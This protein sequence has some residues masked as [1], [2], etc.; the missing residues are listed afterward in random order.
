MHKTRN[1]RRGEK[2][3]QKNCKIFGKE[4]EKKETERTQ[5]TKHITIN[6]EFLRF[7]SGNR[8][9]THTNKRRKKNGEEKR[10]E[11]KSI[12]YEVEQNNK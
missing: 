12:G 2:L 11:W 9:H 7:A 8:W 10:Y 3:T 5:Q 4:T 1:E 6:R